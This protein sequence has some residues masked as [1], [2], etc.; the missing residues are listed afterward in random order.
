MRMPGI[1]LP[2]CG[3]SAEYFPQFHG[4]GQLRESAA[5]HPAAVEKSRCGRMGLGGRIRCR[6]FAAGSP[7]RYRKTVRCESMTCKYL[8]LLEA[9]SKSPVCCR[10]FA[11]ARGPFGRKR[12]SE[13]AES[14]R[15]RLKRFGCNAILSAA[16]PSIFQN[17]ASS[18]AQDK[19]SG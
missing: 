18:D 14:A 8:S 5:C 19:T 16:L 10:S 4:I 11:L 7:Q 15:M 12:V 2:A 17:F 9:R 6:D 3:F 1:R 13:I